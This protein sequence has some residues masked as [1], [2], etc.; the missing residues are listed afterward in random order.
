MVIKTKYSLGLI[1][2]D[3]TAPVEPDFESVTSTIP[4]KNQ[5]KP[6]RIEQVGPF[7]DYAGFRLVTNSGTTQPKIKTNSHA[8]LRPIHYSQVVIR[9][10]P[11]GQYQ[12]GTTPPTLKLPVSTT[13]YKPQRYATTPDAEDDEIVP[14]G[15]LTNDSTSK[16]VLEPIFTTVPSTS[17]IRKSSKTKSKTNSIPHHTLLTT[18]FPNDKADDEIVPIPEGTFDP[19]PVS[20]IVVVPSHT[21]IPFHSQIKVKPSAK[22]TPTLVSNK[23]ECLTNDNNDGND[24]VETVDRAVATVNVPQTETTD[25]RRNH[26]KKNRPARDEREH[27][28]DA[29]TRTGVVKTR[30]LRNTGAKKKQSLPSAVMDLG[31][32][33]TSNNGMPAVDN[34]DNAS[35]MT[36]TTKKHREKYIRKIDI[37]NIFF[38]TDTATETQHPTKR[39]KHRKR[40][41]RRNRTQ[42]YGKQAANSDERT[43][44]QNAE[45]IPINKR[46]NQVRMVVVVM[47]MTT[48][49]PKTMTQARRL[50]SMTTGARGDLIVRIQSMSK[51]CKP[52]VSP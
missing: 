7:I 14:E 20:V 27:R 42:R 3:D 41:P 46:G 33:I 50:H 39:K 31:T 30:E 24:A 28:R 8:P 26:K 9:K 47:T 49:I 52:I 16:T 43:G 5:N 36:G 32:M 18:V 29:D 1:F 45:W 51:I 21:S 19:D 40:K 13:V 6:P 48:R 10:D 35:T 12:E 44:G 38:D 2:P 11:P 22:P 23:Y 15:M 17:P 4:T 34:E 37:S 25:N